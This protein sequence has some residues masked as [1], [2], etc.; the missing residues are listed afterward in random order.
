[1]SGVR[2]IA[3]LVGT[4]AFLGSVVGFAFMLKQVQGENLTKEIGLEQ[5]LG[6]QVPKD[7]VFTD[8]TGKK[9]TIGSLMN[10]KPTVLMLAF[11]RCIDVS[12]TC[13]LEMEG[14]L[15]SFRSMQR[16]TIG[17]DFNVIT[18]GIH[19]KETYDLAAAKKRDAIKQYGRPEA[20]NGWHFLTGDLPEIKKVADAVGFKFRYDEAKDR[21]V[22]PAG[23]ILLTPE[24]KVSK[25]FFGADYPAKV[26][27]DSIL[28]A[29]R[30]TIGTEG[31]PILL[32]CFMYD[33]NTGKT[34]LHVKNA[35]KVT[36]GGTLLILAVSIVMMSRRR[37]EEEAA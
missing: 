27:R 3:W 26:L 2:K 37:R 31:V 15:K 34:R 17:K 32:G 23:L 29:G 9:V 25:V 6:A 1:M 18:L 16:D 12:G 35:L 19:P 36:G 5:K 11:Y 7:A 10:G 24:A 28:V 20:E 8:S 22:H 14:S 30:G 21:I 4:T 13:F 33:E